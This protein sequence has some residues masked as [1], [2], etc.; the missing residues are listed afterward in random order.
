MSFRSR[1]ISSVIALSVSA[2]QS[3]HTQEPEI[4]SDPAA[5]VDPSGAAA[6]TSVEALRPTPTPDPTPASTPRPPKYS[7]N[8]V[9]ISEPV[10][11]ITFD[12]GPHPKLTPQLLD[13]LKERGVKATFFVVGTNAAEY[14]EILQRMVAEGHEV[15][16]HSWSH[17]A[18]NRQGTAGVASQ[19]NRT[20]D[21]IKKAIGHAPTLMRPPYGATNTALTRRINEEFG[22]KVIMWSVDPLDWR[23][24][25]ADRVK[26][27]IVNGAA[28]GAIILVHDIHPTSVAAM[29]GTLDALLAKGYKFATVSELLAME[30]GGKASPIP[31]PGTLLLAAPPAAEPDAQPFEVQ[32]FELVP[33]E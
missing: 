6:T 8:S 20:N 31:T 2:C 17:V 30:G 32:R 14:P 18:L 5:L 4:S 16:N 24:R 25:N 15:A 10:V 28:P 29:P 27:E 1:W 12:D 26:R 21:A 19:L 33:T 7:Y 23:Y 11:A 13:I 9:E 3:V 22:M